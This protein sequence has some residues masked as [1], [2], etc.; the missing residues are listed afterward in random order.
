MYSSDE[1][2]RHY[3]KLHPTPAQEATKLAANPPMY[4]FLWHPPAHLRP[5]IKK[6]GYKQFPKCYNGCLI[7]FVDQLY[8][9]PG[10]NLVF[11]FKTYR[12]FYVGSKLMTSRR[13]QNAYYHSRDMSCL[14]ACPELE[15]ITIE[16]CYIEWTCFTR[17]TEAHKTILRKRHHW[18][19]IR[20]NRAEVFNDS[21]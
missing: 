18:I 5:P 6:Q 12:Q 1:E 9:D 13:L 15:D 10:K 4:C 19:P 14:R 17:L 2:L 8:N 7:P 16:K 3:Y 20:R 11:R 21:D